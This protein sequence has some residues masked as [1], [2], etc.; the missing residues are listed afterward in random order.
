MAPQPHNYAEFD[1]KMLACIAA[2]QNTAAALTSAMG[3]EAKPLMK[4]PG[5]EF[6]V[7]DR[8]LQA[9]RKTKLI[10]CERRGALVVWTLTA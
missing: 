9:L 8:R 3:A 10:A 1:K 4:R 2:G 7:V 5:E 6:R